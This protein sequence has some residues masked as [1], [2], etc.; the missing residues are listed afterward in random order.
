L[1][2]SGRFLYE[3]DNRYHSRKLKTDG[4]TVRYVVPRRKNN[5]FKP[6]TIAQCSEMLN[7]QSQGNTFCLS[8]FT[9]YQQRAVAVQYTAL[10]KPQ[11]CRAQ[12]GNFETEYWVRYNTNASNQDSSLLLWNPQV[13]HCVGGGGG[14]GGGEGEAILS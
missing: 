7:F 9:S 12:F 3:A 10:P 14:G 5:R 4:R 2:T 1:F 13:Y 8:D 11:D 6:K